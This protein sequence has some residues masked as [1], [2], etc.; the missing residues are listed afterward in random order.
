[1]GLIS[2]NTVF[3]T[4]LILVRFEKA[5]KRRERRSERRKGLTLVV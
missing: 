1:M 3:G 2:N 4:A 5:I